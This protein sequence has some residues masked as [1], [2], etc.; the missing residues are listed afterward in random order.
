MNIHELDKED[1]DMI[2]KVAQILYLKHRH[3]LG[4]YTA[5]D[6]VGKFYQEKL[7]YHDP[8][9]GHSLKMFCERSMRHLILNMKRDVANEA[10]KYSGFKMDPT[11]TGDILE[12]VVVKNYG[13]EGEGVSSRHTLYTRCVAP[14]LYYDENGLYD[15][16]PFGGVSYR[17][18]E[19]ISNNLRK[20]Q[21]SKVEKY[22]IEF[23]LECGKTMDDIKKMP[24]RTAL[25]NKRKKLLEKDSRK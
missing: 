4:N 6:I 17:M 24:I 12:V 19:W 23:L 9:T 11:M 22:I 21:I 13:D 16:L 7:S 2:H 20:G 10:K 8:L 14:D 18:R 5:A 3:H 15:D 1:S 25:E